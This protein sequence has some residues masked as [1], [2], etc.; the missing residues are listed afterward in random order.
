MVIY[1]RQGIP[2]SARATNQKGIGGLHRAVFFTRAWIDDLRRQ[3]YASTRSSKLD[4]AGDLWPTLKKEMCFVYDVTRSGFTN[5]AHYVP[6]A[7]SEEAITRI[8][9][10]L[11][12]GHFADERAYD[13]A[14]RRHIDDDLSH[15]VGGNVDDPTKAA[16]DVLRDVRDYVRYAVD[17]GGLTEESHRHFLAEVIPVMYRISAG[18]PKERN[19]ELIALINSGIAAFGPGPNPTL[20]FDQARACF[21]LRSTCLDHPVERHLDVLIRARTDCTVYPEK[22]DSVLIRNMLHRG[23]LRP[24]KNGEFHPGGLDI[25]LSQNV[26]SATGHTQ[27][28]LWALGIVAEGANYCTYVLPRA[29]VN[30]RFLQFS[31]RCALKMFAW[32]EAQ[33][34][35]P[36]VPITAPLPALSNV[37]SH[38]ED[39]RSSGIQWHEVFMEPLQHEHGLTRMAPSDGS[40]GITGARRSR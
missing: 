35:Q 20:S 25:D 1:S 26:I 9:S 17:Y 23:T 27:P 36:P 40:L 24:H 3:K 30:S 10:P 38:R 8:L 15:A 37:A 13:D 33:H 18:A 16:T 4:Y 6:S 29:L 39:A 21:S 12:S 28:N 2:F 22:Q 7:E 11:G 19:M 31:G 14:V 5:P 32:L 34:A